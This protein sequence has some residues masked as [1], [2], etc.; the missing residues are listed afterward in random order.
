MKES[1]MHRR[2]EPKPWPGLLWSGIATSL[3]YGL[4]FAFLN[5]KEML[6][7]FMKRENWYLPV[8]TAL[9]FSVAHGAF[10]S[11]FW[12]VLGVRAKSPA[13]KG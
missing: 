8:V 3:C 5:D 10:T 2:S 6:A 9:I 12:E 11:Y 7:L 13:G 4:L 1:A